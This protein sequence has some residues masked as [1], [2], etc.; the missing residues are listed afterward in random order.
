MLG[1][2]LELTANPIEEDATEAMALA[3]LKPL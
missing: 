3:K 1:N 2:D